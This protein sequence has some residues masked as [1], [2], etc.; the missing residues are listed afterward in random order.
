MSL[1]KLRAGHALFCLIL[2]SWTNRTVNPKSKIKDIIRRIH[3]CG[4]KT[5]HGLYR[6]G[7]KKFFNETSQ[8]AD[9]FLAIESCFCPQFWQKSST[10]RLSKFFGMFQTCFKKAFLSFPWLVFYIHFLSMVYCVQVSLGTGM[11]ANESSDFIDHQSDRWGGN[12]S[13]QSL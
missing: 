8:N 6:L 4:E 3:F 10:L 2:S 9:R 1:V 12:L 11:D 7:A 5:R 13:L